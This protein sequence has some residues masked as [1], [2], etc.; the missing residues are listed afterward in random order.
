MCTFFVLRL[1]CKGNVSM[2]LMELDHSKGAIV[3]LDEI[4]PVST[5][6][7]TIEYRGPHK[8]DRVKRVKR[9][10]D[11]TALMDLVVASSEPRRLIGLKLE[12][13]DDNGRKE[14][15]VTVFLNGNL[16]HPH[17]FA[18][19]TTVDVPLPISTTVKRAYHPG[20]KIAFVPVDVY[21]GTRH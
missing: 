11:K 3:E 6:V 20:D 5:T 10:P 9:T 8:R 16:Q 7:K 13:K 19:P 1:N 4:V 15:P 17:D 14:S 21:T 12:G 18:P 2:S